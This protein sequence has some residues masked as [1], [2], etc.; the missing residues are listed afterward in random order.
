MLALNEPDAMVVAALHDEDACGRH[1]AWRPWRSYA[2]LY[3][4]AKQVSDADSPDDLREASRSRMYIEQGRMEAI[5][6]ASR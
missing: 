3:L 2:S 4:E 5:D 1:Q 6:G